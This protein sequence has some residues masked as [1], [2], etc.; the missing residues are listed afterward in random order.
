M[1]LK[2]RSKTTPSRSNS[3][4][5]ANS[6]M[7][8]AQHE[9]L[10][11]NNNNNNINDDDD[12]EAHHQEPVVII[13]LSQDDEDD[14]DIVHSNLPAPS[15]TKKRKVLLGLAVPVVLMLAF[16]ML[17]TDTPL[18]TSNTYNMR[19]YGVRA[20]RNVTNASK[21]LQQ[22]TN[23]MK[24]ET[25]QEQQQIP[26][27]QNTDPSPST[28]TAPHFHLPN[29]FASAPSSTRLASLVKAEERPLPVVVDRGEKV[30]AAVGVGVGVVPVKVVSASEALVCRKSVL[31]YVINATNGKDEC[32]GLQK[33]FDETCS[34]EDEDTPALEDVNSADIW[35]GQAPDTDTRDNN[36]RRRRRMTEQ[37]RLRR[38]K[39]QDLWTFMTEEAY[40]YWELL[41][42]HLNPWFRK[43]RF[44]PED[45]ISKVYPKA[46]RQQIMREKR[47]RRQK[48]R[49]LEQEGDDIDA[50]A[51][52]LLDD[53]E[54]AAQEQVNEE[55]VDDGDDGDDSLLG[56]ITISAD[57]SSAD[58]VVSVAEAEEPPPAKPAATLKPHTILSLPTG[59]LHVSGKTLENTLLLQHEDQVINHLKKVAANATNATQID[60]KEDAAA[61]AKAVADT[62]ELVSA[63]LN[64]PTSIEA[65]TCCASILNVYHEN[66][67]VD[68]EEDVSDQRLFIV[69]LIMAFCGM[70]K[71]LIR[72]FRIR[73]L[74]E[75]AG[76]ILVGVA[77]GY[78]STFFPH[79]DLSFD[80]NWFLRILV[81]PIVFEAAL[82]IDKKTFNRHLV[83]ILFYSTLGTLLATLLTASIVHTG[84]SWLGR[85]CETIPYIES[86]IFG[87]LISSIDPIA[88]LSVL[89][90]MGMS[91]TDTLY[92]LVFG[93]SLLNDG[94]AIVLFE[95]LE[96]FLDT[97]MVIDRDT[98]AAAF[99]HFFVVASGS[100]LVGVGSGI[101]CTLYYWS[102]HGCQTPLVE[103]LMF[104][105][106]ALFPYYVCDGIGWSGIVSI[107]TVGFLMDM[108]VVGVGEDDDDES[109]H[110][111]EEGVRE[112]EVVNRVPEKKK[113]RPL[114][115]GEGHLSPIA[116]THIGFVTEI[117]ATMM[118]TAIFAYLGLFLFSHRYHWNGFHIFISIFACSL[119]R[120]IMIPV[121]SAAANAITSAQKYQN[122][123][124]GRHKNTPA[125][126]VIVDRK[127]QMVLW[128]A[129][130]RGAMSFALVEHIPLF[131][132]VTGEGT[133]VKA[134]LKAMTSAC[135]MFTVFVL[136][137]STNYFMDYIGLSP[138]AKNE[139][140]FARKSE[141]VPLAVRM[142]GNRETSRG[143]DDSGK[144][145]KTRQRVRA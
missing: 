98:I 76:C 24:E 109:R 101:M 17:S 110:S 126:G 139:K 58:T 65:R 15:F 68:A 130:L 106:W 31:D 30:A 92:V 81:P 44:C 33:A 145:G 129:G 105:C 107:V 141:M 96:R 34:Q 51:D 79:H 47:K 100:I 40:Q 37:R 117:V 56:N 140:N 95:T 70:V 73:W 84:T 91:D 46:K 82:S 69:V 32:H 97:N 88:V 60:A 55:V 27:Q 38:W 4:I 36:G 113:Y 11:N 124:R 93:E 7:S 26:Q 144:T 49:R 133:R 39:Q 72:H 78:A 86:L 63:V 9:F 5:S 6:G 134:E 35:L 136:G 14:F 118:E 29:P 111:H 83:P 54:N 45:A 143:M 138:A 16:R 48:R 108:Y 13:S 89:S 10:D 121:L 52:M 132:A 23:E 122:K 1:S 22:E 127:M 77:S 41:N 8:A 64:D 67:N 128:F 59:A 104:L 135:I 28:S 18:P 12:D 90:N 2:P 42:Q 123:C 53:V 137:G 61:S 103:V 85:F 25:V 99:A 43:P 21:K 125:M 74:P 87:S 80:G 116:R 119:S 3:G 66:C 131:D 120:A 94:V 102:F 62:S 115:S 142:N 19:S 75:A 112:Q 71:S 114:F 20:K 50:P 57:E